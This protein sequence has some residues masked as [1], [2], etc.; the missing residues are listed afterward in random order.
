MATKE[1]SLLESIYQ[2]VKMIPTS[3]IL[4]KY[5]TNSG[6]SH[7][8]IIDLPEG[9]K[10]VN[11]CSEDYAL[12]SNKELFEPLIQ[13][14]QEDYTIEA[15]AINYKNS[16]FFVDFVIKDK[17]FAITKKD[18]V[19]FKM[20][21]QNSYDGRLKFRLQ[22]GLW[23]QICSNGMMGWSNDKAAIFMH[24][25]SIGDG[26]YLVQTSNYIK[27]YM[28]DKDAVLTPYKELAEIP[29]TKLEASVEDVLDSTDFP[30]RWK[31]PVM[32][33]FTEETEKLKVPPTQY[34]LYNAFNFQL[35]HNRDLAL[36]E[37]AR[38]K[39]D[40]EVFEAIYNS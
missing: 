10:I 7:C 34:A 16:R 33:K 19:N 35:N 18:M 12:I 8:V 39:L 37:H 38:E 23:R 11:F 6:N 36:E 20:R 9:P 1:K 26:Q 3:D 31:E 13:S 15:H 29:V 25:S 2:P 27:K 32:L 24:T 30:K 21:F 14:L 28:S 40:R 17:A 4:P 5:Q 22:G